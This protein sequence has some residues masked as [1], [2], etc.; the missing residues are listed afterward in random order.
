MAVRDNDGDGEDGGPPP[1]VVAL[2]HLMSLEQRRQRGVRG[3]DVIDE[4]SDG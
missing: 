1:V 4:S 2:A 3:Y